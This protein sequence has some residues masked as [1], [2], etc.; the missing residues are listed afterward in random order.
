MP[1]KVQ[2]VKARVLRGF[3]YVDALP[4]DTWART[5]T[6][7][8]AGQVIT[9]RLRDAIEA[10][11]TKKVEILREEPEQPA[12]VIPNDLKPAGKTKHDEAKKL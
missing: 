5:A 7:K 6:P 8:V 12:P 9:M 4:N 1:Q 2:T 10:R 11:T 3:Y